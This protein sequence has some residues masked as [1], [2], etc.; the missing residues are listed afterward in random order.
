M[1][2]PSRIPSTL[3]PTTQDIFI[4]IEPSPKPEDLSSSSTTPP[5]QITPTNAVSWSLQIQKQKKKPEDYEN[6]RKNKY[7][8]YFKESEILPIPELVQAVKPKT[9]SFVITDIKTRRIANVNKEKFE[10][11]LKSVGIPGKY[12]CRRSFATWDVLL[13]TEEQ[14]KKLATSNINTKYFRLQP[15]YLGKRHIKVTVCNASMELNGDVLAA[16]LS[17]HGG[18]EEYKLITSAHGT[19]F[20]DYVFTMILDRGGFHSIPH[21]IIYRD[22]TMMVV[23]EG[24]KPLCWNCKKLGHFSR[25]C[26]QK[27]TITGPKTTSTTSDTINTTTMTTK[28]TTAAASTNSNPETGVQPEKEEGWTLVKRNKKKSPKKAATT[29]TTTT[30]AATPATIQTLNK[31]KSQNLQQEET[32]AT[33]NLKRRDSGD[34]EK[35]G[36]RKNNRKQTPPNQKKKNLSLSNPSN[37]HPK[38]QQEKHSPSDRNQKKRHSLHLNDQPKLSLPHNIL[39]KTLLNSHYLQ[40][41]LRYHP[42]QPQ[43]YYPGPIRRQETHS[44]RHQHLALCDD[45][46][47]PPEMSSK[48]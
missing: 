20:G 32:E 36:G 15:E 28:T 23:V 4:D 47:R 3:L 2:E 17:T 38:D 25:S 16:Y 43:N 10:E 27:T 35:E 24:R 37:Q 13:P 40:H 1:G 14:A 22:T 46:D 39:L 48:H 21:T 7:A 30:I 19:A 41:H 44:R 12:I 6:D 5:G 29:I 26:L 31:K 9:I 33:F 8:K 42:F 45:P 18:V 34:T 11:T